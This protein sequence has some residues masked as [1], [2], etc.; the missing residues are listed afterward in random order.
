MGGHAPREMDVG[1]LGARMPVGNAVDGVGDQHHVVEGAGADA[2]ARQHLVVGPHVVADLEHRGVLQHRLQDREGAVQADLG[3]RP[4][5]AEGEHPLPGGAGV[6]EGDVAGAA[7][8]RGE[9]DADEGRGRH[10]RA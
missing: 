7:R 2:Q 8:A 10:P 3:R 9:R 1:E 5:I 4:F 6:A